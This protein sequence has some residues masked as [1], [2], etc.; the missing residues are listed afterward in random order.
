MPLGYLRAVGGLLQ[1]QNQREQQDYERQQTELARQDRLQ[2]S[3]AALLAR[4]QELEY[5]QGR[6]KAADFR[7]GQQDLQK[8]YTEGYVPTEQLHAEAQ[9][10]Q[11]A[12]GAMMAPGGQF[13]QT[14]IGT[15]L[16][17]A[18]TQAAKAPTMLT[19]ANTAL[20]K[21][22]PSQAEQAREDQQRARREELA[23]AQ[24]NARTIAG[25]NNTAR[26]EQAAAAAEARREAAADRA[27][28]AGAGKQNMNDQRMFQREQSL[29][30]DYK[31]NAVVKNAYGTAA[32]IAQLQAGLKGNSG[33]DDLALIYGTVKLFDPGSVVKEGE[34]KLTRS[35]Q[36][37]PGRLSLLVSN[38][39]SGKLLTPEQ[40]KQIET[41]LANQ[42][43]ASRSSI[44][45]IQQ[46]YGERSHRWGADSSF[47]APDPFR[48]S[49]A[50][51]AR[52]SAPPSPAAPTRPTQTLAPPNAR[53]KSILNNLLKPGG[54]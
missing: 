50:E 23:G 29:Q 45:P 9:Q 32:S 18:G 44:A 5:N 1:G 33:M 27:A 2:Q 43:D 8:A 26:A 20:T 19:Y 46:D 36:S 6:D 34:I 22:R 47:V 11:T 31:N 14:G 38:V 37:L 49:G 42:V 4:R 53:Q 16:A 39:N 25:M 15:A 7:Q 30:S 35:A 17:A 48:T 28:L 12:G 3:A 13:D 10:A 52:V 54:P 51:G 21:G 41:L 40:R 24:E